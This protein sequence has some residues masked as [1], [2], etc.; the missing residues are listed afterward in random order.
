MFCYQIHNANHTC[1]AN[2]THIL[3]H[4]ISPTLVDSHQVARLIYAIG[5]HLGRNQ[6]IRLQQTHLA[7]LRKGT[8]LGSISQFL[9]ELLHLLFQVSIALGQFLIYLGEREKGFHTGIPFVELT[10]HGIS[11]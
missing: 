6:M 11:R 1:T 9:G 2:H 10:R 8:V 3:A 7:A 5:N 4:T